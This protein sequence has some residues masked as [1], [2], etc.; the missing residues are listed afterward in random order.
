MTLVPCGDTVQAQVVVSPSLVHPCA[1]R[2]LVVRKLQSRQDSAS[3]AWM[4]APTPPFSSLAARATAARL[5]A[6]TPHPPAPL[7]GSEVITPGPHPGQVVPF[8]P[9]SGW[10]V[11]LA[12]TKW[13]RQKVPWWGVIPEV[14]EL[15][16][17][18]GT[19]FRGGRLNC[20]NA[21]AVSIASRPS[22]DCSDM[23]RTLNGET[24]NGATNAL[25]CGLRNCLTTS[26]GPR[27]RHRPPASA[28]AWMYRR[29]ARACA[30]RRSEP[31]A[32]LVSA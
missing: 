19:H 2:R 27:L 11:F 24:L 25:R 28:A 29:P 7:P 17:A 15:G 1:Q 8:V 6:P 23:T 9:R 21:Y 12:V 3:L 10:A 4:G 26:R 13:N 20:F 30:G 14:G 31:W 16:R 5:C 32:E 18:G 22:R